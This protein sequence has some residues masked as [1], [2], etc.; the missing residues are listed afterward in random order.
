M[1]YIKEYYNYNDKYYHGSN[2][3][4]D[5]LKMM[6]PESGESKFLGDGIYIS[7]NKDISEK[8]GK[9]LYEVSLSED[10][11]SLQYMEDIPLDKFT[12]IFK[13]FI[14]SDNSD[15]N[16]IGESMESDLEDDDIWYGKQLITEIERE[17][18]DVNETLLD[19]GYNSVEAPIN[20]LNQFRGNS[21]SDRNINVIKHNILSIKKLN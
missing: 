13:Y 9:F 20:M 15:Y 14:E 12:E 11:K 8:Y 18:L 5:T 7:N 16:Y 2:I 10:L 3:E 1:K 17:G 21:D 19:I 6:P 4:L